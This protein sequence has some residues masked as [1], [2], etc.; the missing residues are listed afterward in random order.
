[1]TADRE[2]QSAP[3]LDTIEFRALLDTAVDTIITIDRTGSV[4]EFNAAAQ[5]LFGYTAA[6]VMGKNVVILMPEPDRSQH[7][8]YLKRYLST[9]EKRIIG[10][11]REVEG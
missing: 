9:G 8:D 2:E 10:I 1:M 5:R 3:G 6:D 11:G 4:L 7:D